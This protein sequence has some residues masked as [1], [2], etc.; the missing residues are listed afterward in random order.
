MNKEAGVYKFLS[1]HLSYFMHHRGSLTIFREDTSARVVVVL[2]GKERETKEREG[3]RERE[4]GLWV[5]ERERERE[6]ESV[7]RRLRG[8][9]YAG[10]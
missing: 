2:R 3:E 6:R 7:S 10:G 5:G 4:R 8:R 1:I 9:A